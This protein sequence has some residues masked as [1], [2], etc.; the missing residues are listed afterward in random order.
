MGRKP[1]SVISQTKNLFGSRKK[2]VQSMDFSDPEDGSAMSTSLASLLPE[3]TTQS[4]AN[5]S[6]QPSIEEIPDEAESLHPRANAVSSPSA[7][8]EHPPVTNLSNVDPNLIEIIGRFEIMDDYESPDDLGSP[9]DS[10]DDSEDEED[11]NTEIQEISELEIFTETLKRAQKVAVARERELEKGRKRPHRYAG[12]SQRTRE[13]HAKI[14]RDMQKKGFL[15]QRETQLDRL[16]DS[17]I[18]RRRIWVEHRTE[19]TS[20][21]RKMG[22]T[23]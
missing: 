7:S 17:W 20:W 12:N 15:L 11:H 21:G 5:E 10:G 16:V 23:E 19:Q 8:P 9:E 2:T 1:K 4:I 3:G 13:R 18:L 6:R 14:R 22:V